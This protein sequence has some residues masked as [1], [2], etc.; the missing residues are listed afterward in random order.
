MTR[1]TP[2]LLILAAS[3]AGLIGCDNAAKK[4]EQ[5]QQDLTEQRQEAQKEQAEL[6]QEQQE[7]QRDLANDRAEPTRDM[8]GQRGTEPARAGGD[9]AAQGST[10]RM[11]ELKQEQQEERADLQKE[12]AEELQDEKKDLVEAKEDVNAQ[13]ADLVNEQSEKLRDLQKR[14]DELRAKAEGEAE[15]QKAQQVTAALSKFPTQQQSI[16]RDIEALRTVKETNL[17]RAKTQV[18]KK[19][20]SL[21]KTLDRAESSL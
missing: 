16:E 2:R 19:L 3:M 20:S 6:V 5:E 15:G 21:E 13:R 11:G 12:Q 8:A 10:D 17:N 4:V 9:M 7:E 14:A 18:E 1:F